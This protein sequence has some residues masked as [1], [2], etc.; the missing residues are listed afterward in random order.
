MDARQLS[1]LSIERDLQTI[2][3]LPPP[4]AS[5]LAAATVRESFDTAQSFFRAWLALVKGGTSLPTDRVRTVCLSCKKETE[6]EGTALWNRTLLSLVAYHDYAARALIRSGLPKGEVLV[7]GL[8]LDDSTGLCDADFP[9]ETPPHRWTARSLLSSYLHCLVA[10]YFFDLLRRSP[11]R[12][13]EGHLAVFESI[14]HSELA[15]MHREEWRIPDGYQKTL[16]NRLVSSSLEYLVAIYE[17][18]ESWNKEHP[19]GP[20]SAIRLPELSLLARREPPLLRKYGVKHV[21]RVFEQQLALIAQSLGLYV[22]STRTGKRTVDLV[23]ISSD[24]SVRMSFLLEAKTSAKPYALPTKDGRALLEYIGDVKSALSTLPPLRFV[25]LVGHGPARTVAQK[26]AH[27]EAAAAV[28]IRFCA[29]QDL[30]ALRERILGPVPL[31]ALTD[32]I[33]AGPHVLP[34]GFVSAV[35]TSYQAAQSAHARFV[36]EMLSSRELPVTPLPQWA[37]H[38]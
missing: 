10:S 22:V 2:V 14:A 27:L 30:A 34:H 18:G 35:V 38:S 29:A 11:V 9:E 3:A 15:G 37:E 6:L 28:P 12:P 13:P 5:P 33:L 24:P 21:E 32:Q 4:E 1:E 16:A 26:L 31:A 17:Q 25:L 23:C 36:E 8:R 19:V 7:P 20:F